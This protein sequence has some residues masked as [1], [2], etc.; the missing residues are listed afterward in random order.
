MHTHITHLWMSPAA[1]NSEA[2]QFAKTSIIVSDMCHNAVASV[3][4]KI[5]IL[6]AAT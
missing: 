4:I 6:S 2:Q 5:Q 1:E 3:H